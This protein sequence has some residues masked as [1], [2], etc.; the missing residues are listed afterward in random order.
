MT[1][2]QEAFA[3]ALR[4]MTGATIHDL[5]LTRRAMA[6]ILRDEAEI[7]FC[8]REHG[9]LAHVVDGMT[10]TVTRDH[11][12]TTKRNEGSVT[13]FDAAADIHNDLS[14][15]HGGPEGTGYS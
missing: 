12:F 14:E 9:R 15:H 4:A 10:L 3:S 13:P 11:G 2:A 7:I 6:E 8:C 5:C 1:P